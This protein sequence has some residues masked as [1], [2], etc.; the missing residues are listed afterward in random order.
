[1]QGVYFV[2]ERERKT[3]TLFNRFGPVL[4]RIITTASKSNLTKEDLRD[5][6][7]VQFVTF[8]KNYFYVYFS[9]S[10]GGW[11]RDDT[12]GSIEEWFRDGYK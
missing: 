11:G 8:L 12:E 1:M 6:L 5:C 2:I 10:Y 3:T 4:L 9:L 7:V